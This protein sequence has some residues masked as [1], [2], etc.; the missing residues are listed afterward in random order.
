MHNNIR[1]VISFVIACVGCLATALLVLPA[2]AGTNSW[3]AIGPVAY[4]F[5]VDPSSPSTIY[6]VVN[7]NTVIDPSPSSPYTIYPVVYGDTVTKTT[8]GGGH[9][10]DLAVLAPDQVNSLVIVC[11]DGGI[12]TLGPAPCRD[13]RR[14]PAK[15]N[16]SQQ[17]SDRRPRSCRLSSPSLGVRSPIRSSSRRGLARRSGKC[18]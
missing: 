18:R 10:A 12:R 13:T 5:A 3:T 11:R 15:S 1:L 17:S 9:W 2:T 7:R 14:A 8:D 6:S 16:I 4:P